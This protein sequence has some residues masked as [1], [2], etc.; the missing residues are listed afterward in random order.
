MTRGGDCFVASLLAMTLSP[1]PSCP[2]R[3]QR[4]ARLVVELGDELL[5]QSEKL[6][7]LGRRE[8]GEHAR[9]RALRGLGETRE[10]ALAGA[11]Q[12]Q[13]GAAAVART[14]ATADQPGLLEV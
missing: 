4:H 1:F 10:Q 2:P 3:L 7:A 14:D 5:Q 12:R 8:R 9:L 13:A 6:R 11:R